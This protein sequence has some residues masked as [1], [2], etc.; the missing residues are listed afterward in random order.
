V[1][2]WFFLFIAATFETAWTYSVKYMKFADL[3]LLRWHNFYS[4]QIGLP[5]LAPIVGYVVFGIAN[6]Y[7]FSMAIKQI[8]TPT[9]FAVWTATALIMIKLTDVLFFKADWSLP[10]L[11]FLMLIGIGIVGLRVYATA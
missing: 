1:Q 2:A 10:E 6:I 4:P 9:A 11:F 3:K 5:I 7:F 8:P